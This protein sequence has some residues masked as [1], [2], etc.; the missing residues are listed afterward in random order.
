MFD[1]GWTEIATVAVIAI[2]VIGPKDLPKAMRGLARFIGKAKAMIGEFQRN[3][4]DMIKETELEEVKNSIQSAR[5][6]D[7][8]SQIQ[9]TIDPKGEISQAMDFSEEQTDFSQAMSKPAALKPAK[10][11]N[12]A[13]PPAKNKAE[14]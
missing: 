2:I 5:S 14:D 1:I 7:L 9:N 12:P 6:F 4:D 13:Q 11:E 8:K 10:S 3:L